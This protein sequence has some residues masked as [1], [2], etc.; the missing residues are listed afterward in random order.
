MNN[1]QINVEW[2]NFFEWQVLAEYDG[3]GELQHYF[4]YGNYIDEPLVMHRES[5]SEDFYYAHDHLYSTVALIDDNGSVVE[6]YEY[7]AYGT[8]HIMDAGYNTR[9]V[10]SYGNA[11]AFTGR[12]LDVL[13]DGN[14]LSQHSRHRTYDTYT[15]SRSGI[16]SY[17][18]SAL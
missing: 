6:R 13:D 14:L 16:L 12:R 4:I 5:D 1:E 15:C 17:C 3:A 9:T 8:V 11:Y 18:R 2:R 10:S 7:D